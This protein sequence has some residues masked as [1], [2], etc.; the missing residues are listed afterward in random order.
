MCTLQSTGP[1][2]GIHDVKIWSTV[3]IE[4]A[5]G[6]RLVL[7]TDGLMDAASASGERFGLEHLE[8][9]IARASDS[10]LAEL[11]RR[12]VQEVRA[13]CGDRTQEDDMTLVALE[14]QPRRE[15]T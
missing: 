13:F 10:P 14:F 12:I 7:V 5:P 11:P 15:Q 4:T 1:L 3:E 8:A 2:L 9:A 6:D